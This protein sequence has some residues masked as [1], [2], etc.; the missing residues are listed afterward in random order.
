MTGDERRAQAQ[1]QQAEWEATLRAEREARRELAER[2]ARGFTFHDDG[3][4]EGHRHPRS[5]VVGVQYLDGRQRKSVIGRGLA[6]IA[7]GGLTL[8]V[9][10]PN[11]GW[12]TIIIVTL[13]WT[14]TVQ[15]KGGDG[16]AERLYGL[17]L[18]AKVRA[19]VA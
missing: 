18:Q 19:G 4:V 3:T 5:P 6:G 7:T 13:D 2:K 8:L 9:M 11:A 1:A 10:N 16:E 14:H 12:L 17:A 15:T